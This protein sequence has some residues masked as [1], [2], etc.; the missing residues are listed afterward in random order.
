MSSSKITDILKILND[1]IKD[2]NDDYY[3]LIKHNNNYYL[4]EIKPHPYLYFLISFINTFINSSDKKDKF[5]AILNFINWF[6]IFNDYYNI[7]FNY[8]LDIIAKDN[9]ENIEIFNSIIKNCNLDI[10]KNILINNNIKESILFFNYLKKVLK[11]TFNEDLYIIDTIINNLYK[12]NNKEIDDTIDLKYKSSKYIIDSIEIATYDSTKDQLE[13]NYNRH[14]IYINVNLYKKYINNPIIINIFRDFNNYLKKKIDHLKDDN[15]SSKLLDNIKNYKLYYKFIIISN[16]KDEIKDFIKINTITNDITNNNIISNNKNLIQYDNYLIFNNN[17]INYKYNIYGYIHNK[18]FSTTNS[19][20]ELFDYIIYKY[21]NISDIN[22]IANPK[23]NQYNFNNIKLAHK[24]KSCYINNIII[25]LFNSKHKAIFDLLYFLTPITYND[26]RFNHNIIDEDTYYNHVLELKE[27]LLSSF[28]NLDNDSINNTREEI[29]NI[30][31][32]LTN[33]ETYKNE[34]KDIYNDI[35]KLLKQIYIN[36]NIQ[37]LNNVNYKISFNENI[38]LLYDYNKFIFIN[39]FILSLKY[40]IDTIFKFKN[41]TL[42]INSLILYYINDGQE[43]IDKK[44]YYDTNILQYGGHYVCLVN[45]NNKWF[46]YNDLSNNN[47]PDDTPYPYM[48]EYKDINDVIEQALRD[49]SIMP[50]LSTSEAI[51]NRY[52]VINVKSPKEGIIDYRKCYINGI[53]Y[54]AE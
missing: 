1:N 17:D 39:D 6:D 14:I 33:D 40:K 49:Y 20:N 23:F 41:T 13:Y 10:I 27:K 11:T 24:N 47:R 22:S 3:Y 16:N 25:V 18:K 30:F 29:R 48:W 19:S 9:D 32:L 8:N 28:S 42:K 50:D 37:I 26:S 7:Y 51:G 44:G 2:I 53:L 45:N 46:L 4:D 43:Y 35:F 12:I 36:F 34:E 38:N 21:N 5:I 15:I 54:I 31:Y 52:I